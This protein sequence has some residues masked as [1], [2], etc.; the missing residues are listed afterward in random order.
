MTPI[1]IMPVCLNSLNCN[2]RLMTPIDIMPVC[3][4]SHISGRTCAVVS[5][6]DYG[7]RGPWFET[8][9]RQ[10][11]VALSKSHLSTG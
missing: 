1:D 3:L 4:N 11:V 2:G 7:P 6:A 9:P 8:W 10:F 5:L